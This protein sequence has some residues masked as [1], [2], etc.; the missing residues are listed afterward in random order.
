MNQRVKNALKVAS[1]TGVMVA[2]T[3]GQAFADEATT[4]VMT[5]AFQGVKSDTTAGMAVIAPI[6]IGIFGMFYMWRKGIG[7]F[8]T[9]SK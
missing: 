1:A 5:T 9:V 4:A 2:G 3:V 7:F 6:A 8:K